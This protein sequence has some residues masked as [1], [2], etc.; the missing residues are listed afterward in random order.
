MM[1]QKTKK[2]LAC[3]LCFAAVAGSTV[4]CASSGGGTS[5]TS[6]GSASAG[7]DSSGKLSSTERQV[8][9]VLEEN[10]NQPIADY[11]PAQQ[12]IFK[13][14]NIK[15]HFEV[16]S[17]SNYADK[18]KVLLATNNLPDIIRVSSSDIN[19]YGSTGIFLPLNDYFNSMPEFTKLWK[20]TPD[21][22]KTMLEGKL[23]GFPF[24]CREETAFGAGPVIRTDL[25]EKNNLKTPK[26]FDELLDV[27]TKLKKIYPDSSP[28]SVRKGTDKLLSIVAYMLGSGFDGYSNFTGIYYDKDKGKYI[29]GPATEEFKQVLSYLNKAYKAGVLDK[30]YATTTQ[31]QWTEKLT[32]GKSFFFIDNSGFSL[33]YTKDLQKTVPTGKFQLISIPTNTYGQ[34]RA[35]SYATNFTGS[36]FAVSAKA[37]DPET[38]MKF[39]NWTYTK[40]GSNICNYGVPGVSFEEDASENPSFK[41]DYVS[42]F[43]DGKPTPYYA[44]YK[45][46]GITKLNFAPWGCNT[47]TQLEIMKDLGQWSKDEDA[48]WT[49][50]EEDKAYQDPV[51]NP[52]LTKSEASR[53]KELNTSLNTVLEQEYNK[54]IMGMKDIST[55]DEVIAKAKSMGA[56]ELE[57]IYNDANQRS[58]STKVN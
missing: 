34:A 52:P 11:A 7:G 19:D 14:T 31:E 51:I 21:Y 49:T 27:L 1:F 28:W 55:Y 5:G 32:S 57:K 36:Y 16:V 12:Q 8:N 54:Y 50:V 40:H 23:Y 10:E 22:Q 6:A 46:M 17:K 29:Y 38:I 42:K 58:L 15:L 24:I 48:Y 56:T 43:K 45:D 3:L 25:L 9:V 35:V 37:K 33:N 39:M 13:E 41:K 47:K 30:D 20:S 2:A 44:I 4:G 53:V 26:T 18:K